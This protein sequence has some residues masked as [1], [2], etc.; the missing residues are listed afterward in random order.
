M[1]EV[2]NALKLFA[3]MILY[4]ILPNYQGV[5]GGGEGGGGW[6]TIIV[7]IFFAYVN[8]FLLFTSFI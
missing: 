3:W 7:Y 2:I 8:L 4:F 1:P 6:N 5:R